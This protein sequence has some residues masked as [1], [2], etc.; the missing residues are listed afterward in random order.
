MAWGLIASLVACLCYGA[1]TVLQATGARGVAQGEGVDPRLLARVLRSMPF[2][3]GVV[4][5][6]VALVFNL[7]ALRVLPLFAVQAIISANLAVVALGSVLFL[8]ARLGRRDLIAVGAVIGGMVLL[9]LSAG[10]EG[11]DRF[12]MESSWILLAVAVALSAGALALG[13]LSERPHSALLGGLAGVL[14][15]VYAIGVRVLPSFRISAVVTN[16][17]TYAG[18]VAGA[19]AF[20]LFATALQRGSVTVT[21]S[22]VVIGETAVPALT[23]LILLGD[24]TRPGYAVWGVLGFLLAVAGSLALARFGEPADEHVGVAAD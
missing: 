16:P 2:L 3:F 4:F 6:V 19:T 20:L 1:A 18:V 17:A 11:S 24:Q 22:A 5:D 10:H 8:G 14:F 9:G 23:G 12:T 7:A 15:G 13:N 21:T